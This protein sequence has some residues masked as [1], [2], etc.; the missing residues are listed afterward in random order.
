[1]QK[2]NELARLWNGFI[3]HLAINKTHRQK[4]ASPV[5]SYP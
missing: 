3:A 4:Y 1:M 2:K 5:I